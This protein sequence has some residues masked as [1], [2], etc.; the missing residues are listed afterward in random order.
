M[1]P[2][3]VVLAVV[4]ALVVLIGLGW[5][6]DFNDYFHY[7]T[8]APKYEQTRREVFE[9]SRAYNAGTI[10]NIRSAER[11]YITAPAD[12]RAGLASAIVQQ[13]ADYPDEALP[14]DLRHFMQCLRSHQNDTYD[15]S[16]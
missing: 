4:A 3:H 10:Q 6:F 8:F 11:D 13:Y 2:S 12:R 16:Q 14:N 7:K 15:C 9:Q 1:K 5:L